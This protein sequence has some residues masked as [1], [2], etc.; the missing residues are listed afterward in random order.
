MKTEESSLSL[1]PNDP[2][3][4]SILLFP[5]TL[6]SVG[7]ELLVSKEGTSKG[8]TKLQPMVSAKRV[9]NS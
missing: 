6:D 4:D 1:T 9:C 2:L 3:E 7:L 8:P 5:E